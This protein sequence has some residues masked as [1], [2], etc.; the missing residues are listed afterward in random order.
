MNG[1][2]NP[3]S[4]PQPCKKHCGQP[5]RPFP[6]AKVPLL[7]G[8]FFCGMLGCGATP[9]APVRV[10][11]GDYAVEFVPEST[12]L[13][14]LHGDSELIRF[15]ADAWQIGTV[16]QLDERA[17][18]DPYWLEYGDD[19]LAAR[20]P[21]DLIW[22]TADSIAIAAATP[23]R[24]EL[25][26]S[27]SDGQHASL[28][29]EPS[30]PGRFAAVLSPEVRNERPVAY[31]RLR[32]RVDASEAFYGLGGWADEV[33]QRGKVRPMQQEIDLLESKSNEMRVPIPLLIGTRGWG[34]FVESRRPGV[35]AVANKQNDLIET[36]FGTGEDSTNGLRFHLL[37]AEQPIDITRRYYDITGSPRTPAQWALGP[38]IWRNEN[39][40]QAQVLDDVRKI[41]DLDLATSA[42]W[43]DR[44][45][46]TTVNSFDFEK[47]RFP[48]PAAMMAKVRAAGL[49]M[50]LWHAPYLEK[51]SPDLDTAKQR[52]LFPKVSGVLLNNWS[53]PIDFT[54]PEATALWKDRLGR[55]I[56]LGIEGFK[57]DYGED[58]MVGLGSA[59]SG[60]RFADGSDE[61][62][63]HHTYQL[64]YH[65]TYAE[66]LPH[67]GG[68]LLC[69]TG[70]FGDQK[71]VSVIWPGD[72]D[73]TFTRHRESFRG[74]DGKTIQGVGGLPATVVMGLNLGV[75]GFPFF[76]ADTGGFRHSPPDKELYIRWFQ[77]TALSS[78]MQVGDATSQPP[79]EFTADN[80]RDAQTLDLFREFARLHLR[81]FPYEWTLAASISQTGRPIVRP[82]GLAY[83]RLSKHPSDEYLFGDDFLVAPVL[84]R[85][86]RS[87]DVLL[88]PGTWI[89]FTSGAV[90]V[91]DSERTIQI[92]TPIHRLPLFVRA[93]AIIP[94]LR[95]TIDT[96]APASDANVE[97]FANDP[98]QLSV[99]VVPGDK[100][101]EFGVYDGTRLAFDPTSK[102]FSS[103]SGSIFVH[104]TVVQI[105]PVPVE[106]KQVQASGQVLGRVAQ[107]PDLEAVSS[108]WTWSSERSGTL[109]LKLTKAQRSATFQ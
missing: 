26:I 23:Q 11:D 107:S 51:G 7:W 97:S 82:V 10:S 3:P 39:K 70:R 80:G 53:E 73:A 78:V 13:R 52:G 109:T 8:L 100:H 21:P 22:H 56:Q 91:G 49:R 79:W 87:R 50:A 19:V 34:L 66:L 43:I 44:P 77:Q 5:I 4:T 31:L 33:N 76:G 74:R 71:N 94:L 18:F 9:P 37:A 67:E 59:R 54:N 20:E 102:T 90:F 17:S 86:S 1:R 98:G 25:S 60:W 28:R 46:A 2:A 83:P 29:I 108:G 62:T 30:G 47:V 64:L 57:L 6:C 84:T 105:L 42:I 32:P 45:Y 40:D 75:S 95:P 48:D 63:M 69:R 38:W 61:R 85:G 89:D 88:P 36:T 68:F 41:R 16:A 96:L 14:L 27:L 15:P 35:F 24:L 55:Y 65:R 93:G 103:E 58:V 106:P 72:M 99:L 12:T 81:L 101:A 104:G 92:D